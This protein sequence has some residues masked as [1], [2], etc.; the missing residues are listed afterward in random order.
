MQMFT[1]KPKTPTPKAIGHS[2]L[3]TQKASK[4]SEDPGFVP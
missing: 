4:S 3:A 2:Y 1:P